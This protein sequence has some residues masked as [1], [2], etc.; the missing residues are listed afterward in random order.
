[1]AF[2][3]EP[4]AVTTASAEFHVSADNLYAAADYHGQYT[5]FGLLGTGIIVLFNGTHDDFQELLSKR[6]ADAARML[7]GSADE[8]ASAAAAYGRIDEAEAERLDGT[9]PPVARDAVPAMFGG[10]P[11]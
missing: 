2:R 3:V 4:E 10:E 7:T 8:L 11:R 1:M 5:D 6:L 9:Y